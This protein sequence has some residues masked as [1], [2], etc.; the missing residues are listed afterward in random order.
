[1]TLI[2]FLAC[3]TRLQTIPN[4]IEGFMKESNA[5]ARWPRSRALRLAVIVAA[6]A[7]AAL[8]APM[9]TA[10]TGSARAASPAPARLLAAAGPGASGAAE[11]GAAEAAVNSVAENVESDAASGHLPGFAGVMVSPAPAAAVTVYWHGA[12]PAALSRFAATDATA[13]A[14]TLPGAGGIAVRFQPAPYTQAQLTGLR[15]AVTSSP[16]FASS[17]ISSLGFYPQA[18]GLAVTVDSPADLARVRGLP[19]LAHTRIAVRYAVSPVTQLSLPGRD[20]DTP[21]FV[22]GIFLGAMYAGTS[23]ECSSGFGMHYASKQGTRYFVTTAAHCAAKGELR[24]QR[25]WAWGNGKDVGVSFNLKAVDDT[26]SL[27]AAAP[28]GVKGAGGGARIYVGSTSLTSVKGQSTVPV[29]GTASVVPGDLV[30]TS[31]AFSG[32]RTSIRVVTTEMEWTGET[33]DGFEYRVFGAEAIKENRSNAAGQGDS[34]GPVYVFYNGRNDKDGVWAAGIISVGFDSH[35][36]TCTGL[37]YRKCFWDI[38]FPL[39][40]GT[41]TSIEPEMNLEVNVAS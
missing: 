19:A 1:M 4:E 37:R 29:R 36:A 41:P 24:K 16:G 3:W 15:A 39:M 34:G 20:K 40:T 18:T 28:Y 33:P 13:M 14:R 31:G 2:S 35:Y 7:T 30:N 23:Y 6:T 22:G 8:G 5:S 17:G 12:V 27:Y 32:E 21:P 26:V 9:A 25:F 10:A 11:P 38:G